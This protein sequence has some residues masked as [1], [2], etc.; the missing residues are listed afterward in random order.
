MVI[1]ITAVIF[2]LGWD[3]IRLME[4]DAKIRKAWGILN[5]VAIVATIIFG[6]GF[7]AHAA[8]SGYAKYGELAEE[9]YQDDLGLLACTVWAEAGNQDLRG[10]ELVVDVVLNRVD[11]PE[12]PNTIREVIFDKSQFSTVTD[13]G[14]DKA[15]YNVTQ[16]CYTAVANEL[17]SRNDSKALFF[18]AGG[19]GCGTPMY[20]Y[21]DHYF[22]R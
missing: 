1:A 5:A 22:S 8:P 18:C 7:T 12:Y 19:Y 10:K 20:K 4:A 17:S 11:S 15:Y 3:F 14:L 2:L 13:G 16:D 6:C 21:G 9:I